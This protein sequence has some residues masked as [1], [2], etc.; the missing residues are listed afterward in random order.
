MSDDDIVTYWIRRD[1]ESIGLI[2]ILDL[3]D[4]D[5]GSPLFDL[6]IVPEHRGHGVGREAVRWLAT[7]HLFTVYPELHRIEANTRHDNTA[8]QTLLDRCGYRPEGRM[9]EAWTN[10]MVLDTTPL[11]P[12]RVLQRTWHGN[13]P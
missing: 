13:R 11:D 12:M 3:D 6:R 9:V 4:L 1:G 8:M 10:R 7:A 5:T 2:R